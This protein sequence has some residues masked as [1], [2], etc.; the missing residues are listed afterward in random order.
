MHLAL[1]IPKHIDLLSNQAEEVRTK[2]V[3][4]RVKQ[5]SCPPAE[6]PVCFAYPIPL[7]SP[8]PAVGKSGS[9]AS[10]PEAS[11]AAICRSGTF[12]LGRSSCLLHGGRASV[13]ETDGSPWDTVPEP[14]R[15]H[16]LS[17]P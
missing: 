7:R 6:S 1:W 13:F 5:V 9:P 4:L 10:E 15:N 17:G 8:R 2:F 16:E 14:S 12:L 11:I 3:C